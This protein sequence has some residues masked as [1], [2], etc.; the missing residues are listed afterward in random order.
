LLADLKREDLSH[1]HSKRVCLSRGS[2]SSA[3]SMKRLRKQF[4]WI[5]LVVLL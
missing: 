1:V 3:N 2:H 5:A 4:D